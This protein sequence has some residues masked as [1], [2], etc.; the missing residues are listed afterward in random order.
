MPDSIPVVV[1]ATPARRPISVKRTI[2]SAPAGP[3]LRYSRWKPGRG[4]PAG[5]WLATNRSASPSPSTSAA[6]AP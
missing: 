1:V 4:A 3:S 2:P 5:P 6:A